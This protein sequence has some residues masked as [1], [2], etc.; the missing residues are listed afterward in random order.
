MRY[1]LLLTLPIAL[2]G[3]ACERTVRQSRES[4]IPLVITG[5]DFAFD[6]PDTIPS[7]VVNLT[8]INDGPSYHHVQIVRIAQSLPLDAILDSLRP[9]GV[10][11]SWLVPV[12]GAE[13]AD[14]IWRRVTVSLALTPGRYLLLCRITTPD[15][16]VHSVLGMVRPIVVTGAAAQTVREP[17]ADTTVALR[18]YAILGPDTLRAGTWRFRALNEG[19]HEHHVAI[20]RLASGRT[21]SDVIR[22]PPGPT[23]VFDVLGGTAGLAPRGTNVVELTLRPG[24]YVYLCFVIDQPSRREHYQMGMLR[25]LTVVP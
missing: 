3:S 2:F 6:A 22:A 5:R 11:P 17:A 13:G 25:G 4:E 9:D 14:S 19:P 1:A 10:L 20:A 12:G 18:D 21:L 16:Q 15:G 23:P 24:Q 8:F 7:G